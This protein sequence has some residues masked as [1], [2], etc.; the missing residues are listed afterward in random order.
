MFGVKGH[1]TSKKP[2][3]KWVCDFLDDAMPLSF[4]LQVT[5]DFFKSH[6]FFH[7]GKMTS[8]SRMLGQ[9]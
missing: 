1:F 4:Q 7:N 9:S 6:N 3:E 5:E 2:Q 8:F